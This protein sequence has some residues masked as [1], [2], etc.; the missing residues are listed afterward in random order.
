MPAARPV[1]LYEPSAPVRTKARR[2][3]IAA[4]QANQDIREDH[5]ADIVDPVAVVVA[6]DE[7][8]VLRRDAAG[9]AVFLEGIIHARVAGS[10]TNVRDEIVALSV[11]PPMPL[12]TPFTVPTV[13]W[14]ASVSPA[15]R[16]ESSS[17]TR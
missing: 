9:D 11:C 8:A 14:L 10:Q 16:V 3:Q 5:L 6:E 7:S 13:N 1:K 15:G 17:T 2:G 12:M 4:G